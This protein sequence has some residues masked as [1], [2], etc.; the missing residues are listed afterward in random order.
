MYSLSKQLYMF[1]P[2]DNDP[3]DN[4][5][6]KQEP[7]P[8]EPHEEWQ[9]IGVDELTAKQIEYNNPVS[10]EQDKILAAEVAS[11]NKDIKLLN[12]SELQRLE[13]MNVEDIMIPSP[14]RER[15]RR[16]EHS[17]PE[18]VHEPEV[19]PILND[20]TVVDCDGK[21]DDS[22]EFLDEYT[23]GYISGYEE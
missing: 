17:T 12:E 18:V 20:D 23:D 21:K 15:I 11:G 4:D 13:K 1:D 10:S 2:Y 3:Y 6:Y 14:F 7:L 9:P 22:E 8:P 5:P 19:I 16:E